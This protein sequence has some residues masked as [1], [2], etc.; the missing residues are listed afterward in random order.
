MLML[1]V[2]S[3]QGFAFVPDDAPPRLVRFVGPGAM[4][5]K[6][7][8]S[9]YDASNNLLIVDRAIYDALSLEQQRAVLRTHEKFLTVL[10][11]GENI[12]DVEFEVIE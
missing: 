12:V 6:G 4:P 3:K 7:I 1:H 2:V 9:M 11:L 8:V 10:G 5:G